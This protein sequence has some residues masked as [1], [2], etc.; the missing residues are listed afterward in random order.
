METKPWERLPGES[1]EQYSYFELYRDYGPGRSVAKIK[2]LKPD[3]PAAS[4][5]RQYSSKFGWVKRARDWDDHLSKIKIESLEDLF[6]ERIKIEVERGFRR[7]D[8]L[9]EN[10][11]NLRKAGIR[12][13]DNPKPISITSQA[14]AMERNSKA[15]EMTMNMLYMLTGRPTEITKQEIKQE[16]VTHESV[17]DKVRR[18]K[19]ELKESNNVDY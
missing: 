15:K 5:L 9:D 3:L 10:L 1:S 6:E 12:S 14:Y 7:S 8:I 16:T 2:K 4:Y 17:F 18:L 11:V 19:Q 13:E